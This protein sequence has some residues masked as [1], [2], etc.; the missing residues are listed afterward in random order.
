[1][2]NKYDYEQ[3]KHL[4]EQVV[5]ENADKVNRLLS[6]TYI[7][8]DHFVDEFE[9]VLLALDTLPETDNDFMEWLRLDD[10]ELAILFVNCNAVVMGIDAAFKQISPASY[11][12]AQAFLA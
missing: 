2:N 7:S 1:M 3:Q 6:A 12:E 10:A 8:P 5:E 4:I 9:E 11:E